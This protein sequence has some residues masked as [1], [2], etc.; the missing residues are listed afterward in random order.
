MNA[1][2]AHL[3]KKVPLIRR[4]VEERDAAVIERSAAILERDTALAARDSAVTERDT[5]LA[6]RDLA[7]AERN[8]ALAARD[9]AVAQRDMAL[10][11]CHAAFAERDTALTAR[12]TAFAERDRALATHEAAKVA[13]S[14][15]NNVNADSKA[16]N[17]L[18]NRFVRVFQEN[19]FGDNES[20]SGPGS[21]KS[22]PSVAQAVAALEVVRK[23][24]NFE[25][26][27]DIPCGDFNWIY[28]FL[29]YASDVRYKG[30]DIVPMLI[31]RNRKLYPKYEFITLDITSETPP[32]ADLIFAKD[33][34]NHLP[35]ED[36]KKALMNMKNSQSQHRSGDQPPAVEETCGR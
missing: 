7:V 24:T 18:V 26:I 19:L 25:S 34:F 29:G 6:A 21:R 22:S 23:I 30:F 28:A 9:S 32:Y 10:A 27:N 8:T 1:H 16:N 11:E 14:A 5:A 3:V 2:V 35:N 15:T 31:E 20:V 12:D 13:K 33:F 17:I 36:V 4:L